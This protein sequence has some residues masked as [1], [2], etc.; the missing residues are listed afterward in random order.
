M[1]TLVFPKVVSPQMTHL[2]LPGIHPMTHSVL[3]SN[4]PPLPPSPARHVG[5]PM[6]LMGNEDRAPTPLPRTQ[7]AWLAG[8]G[9]FLSPIAPT[10]FPILHQRM[11]ESQ[12]TGRHSSQDSRTRECGG[13][14]SANTP[15]PQTHPR[16][17]CPRTTP[18]PP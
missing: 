12:L 5:T 6:R 10:C 7:G 2:E 13:G 8:P 16:T 4:S 18:S 15:T 17:I 11:S 3:C 9:A 14:A 1:L